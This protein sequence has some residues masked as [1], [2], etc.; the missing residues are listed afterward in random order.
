M[1][2]PPPSMPRTSSK[3]LRPLGRIAAARVG[4]NYLEPI[5]RQRGGLTQY[6][7]PEPSEVRVLDPLDLKLA[8]V[9]MEPPPGVPGPPRIL[10]AHPS[11]EYGVEHQRQPAVLP[12]AAV[13]GNRPVAGLPNREFQDK[14]MVC[15]LDRRG[16][17]LRMR[18]KDLNPAPVPTPRPRHPVSREAVL[19]TDP[20]GADQNRCLDL[21]SDGIPLGSVERLPGLDAGD[22]LARIRQGDAAVCPGKRK[23]NP[24]VIGFATVVL[25]RSPDPLGEQ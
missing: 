1:R 8:T 24:L 11:G 12:H 9:S 5:L 22:G 2:R 16:R 17:R 14:R 19:T 18:W 20:F 4:P 25:P 7:L 21:I 15:A 23:V 13:V 10:N 6:A 3:Y